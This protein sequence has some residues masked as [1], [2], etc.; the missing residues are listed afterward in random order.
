MRDRRNEH[1]IREHYEVERELADRLRRASAEERMTLYSAVY[2][3]LLTRVPH[4]PSLERKTSEEKTASA[5]ALQMGLLRP[6]LREGMTYLEVGPGDCALA[7]AVASRVAKV[8]A[9]D[10]SSELTRVADPPANF[11]LI[12]GDGTSV[13]VPA[14]SVDLA[15]SNQLLEHLHPD[16]AHRQ[17]KNLFAA[18]A[19]GGA[20]VCVTPNRING[21][22]DISRH[23]DRVA[24]GFHL[25]EYTVCELIALFR[26]VGF[27]RV[28]QLVGGKG[29]YRALPVL[30]T[31]AIESVIGLL[32]YRLRLKVSARTPVRQL[33]ANR[34][35]GWKL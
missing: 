24:T 34:V 16:D 12:L 32:P 9:I 21:P 20:Y 25:K 14:G 6:F 28:R 10:V 5:V 1:L 33:L 8:F 23:F 31:R 2:D 7:F 18:I 11:E 30:V 19:P 22:H 3:E 29:S 13:P 27:T 4:H 35:M 26:A 15:Y 17:L